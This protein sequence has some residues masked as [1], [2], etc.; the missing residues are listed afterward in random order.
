MGNFASSLYSAGRSFASAIGSDIST[1]AAGNKYTNSKSTHY[2]V[3]TDHPWSLSKVNSSP[4]LLK[5]VPYI[6][7]KEYEVGESFIANQFAYYTGNIVANVGNETLTKATN[8]LT[9]LGGYGNLIKSDAPNPLTPYENLYK[10]D[11]TTE[12][13]NIYTFPYFDDINFEINTPPWETIDALAE[14]GNAAGS[15]TKAI[16]GNTRGE[17]VNKFTENTGKVFSAGLATT[18]PKIGIA[19]KPRLWSS[20]SPR[21]INIKFPLFNT[22]NSTDWVKNRGLCWVLVNQNLFTKLDF[23]SN[24]PPVFYE[25]SI[26]GQHYSYAAAVTRLT[27]NNR[28]NMRNLLDPNKYSCIVPDAY[29]VNITLEDL[30]MPSRNLFQAIQTKA[31]EVTTSKKQGIINNINKQTSNINATIPTFN[32]NLTNFTSSPTPFKSYPSTPGSGPLV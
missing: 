28:G 23:I 18:A 6:T 25:I 13:G 32:Q 11:G 20:H 2:N 16:L 19:D 30:V 15:L 27:I 24:V 14:A 1:D 7:L 26:P 22:L 8:Y 3:V 31:G 29:E 4:D 10:K 9:Q 5:E 21:S 12:T 17:A